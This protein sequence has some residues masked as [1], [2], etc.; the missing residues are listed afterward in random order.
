MLV[1]R[2]G[3]QPAFHQD[4]CP[5]FQPPWLGSAGVF[6][7]VS[8]SA[9]LVPKRKKADCEGAKGQGDEMAEVWHG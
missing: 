4:P 3:T 1:P 6:H 8:V 9:G 7:L 2:Q 5:G